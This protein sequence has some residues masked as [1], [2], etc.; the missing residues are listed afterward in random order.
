MFAKFVRK[1][2]QNLKSSKGITIPTLGTDHINARCVRKG[3]P[4]RV[5]LQ[6]IIGFTLE[7][8][9]TYA[10]FVIRDLQSPKF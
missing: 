1:G 4:N 3:S 2:F 6:F 8:S 5:S 9:H 7:R 10:S